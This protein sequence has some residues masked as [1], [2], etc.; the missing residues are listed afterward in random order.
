MRQPT[1]HYGYVSLP[2]IRG[3]LTTAELPHTNWMNCTR[4][5]E[6]MECSSGMQQRNTPALKCPTSPNTYHVITH[7]HMLIYQFS[8][9][10]Q[11]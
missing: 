10:C 2:F 6:P 1:Y 3:G 9:D 7:L 11:S 8:R 4:I 5:A